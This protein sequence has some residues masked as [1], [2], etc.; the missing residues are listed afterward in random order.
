MKIAFVFTL[1]I[2]DFLTQ[3]ESDKSYMIN[4]VVYFGL[5]LIVPKTTKK[6]LKVE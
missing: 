5:N 3:Q 6:Q 2:F 4:L 1:Y